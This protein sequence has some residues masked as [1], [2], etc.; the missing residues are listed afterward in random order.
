MIS[1]SEVY[2]KNIFEE[3]TIEQA[4]V[5]TIQA[6]KKITILTDSMYT[7]RQMVNAS[8]EPLCAVCFQEP[9][10]L[11]SIPCGHTFC[12]SCGSKQLT[13]CY[14]CR[15]PVKDRIKIYFS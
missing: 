3:N 6:L 9:V 7:I 11:V 1:A 4:Y 8:T 13:T 2:L 12:V 14:I 5:E 15:I 10:R